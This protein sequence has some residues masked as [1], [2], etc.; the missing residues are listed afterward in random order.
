[1]NEHFS[2]PNNPSAISSSGN[3]E[4]YKTEESPPNFCWYSTPPLCAFFPLKAAL[5]NDR[6]RYRNLPSVLS[7]I[8]RSHLYGYSKLPATGNNSK[9]P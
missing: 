9:L 8:F 1:M 7:P 3:I 2:I 5:S 6:H 4:T